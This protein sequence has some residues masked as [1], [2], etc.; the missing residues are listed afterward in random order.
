M[1]RTAASSS[2]AR[3]RVLE[4]ATR[5]F[6]AEGIHA[7]G[8]DRIIAEAGVAKAT[9]YSHFPAKS[10]LIRE[11]LSEQNDAQRAMVESMIS[12]CRAK[13]RSPRQT[14]FKIFDAVGD[15][16]CVPGYR[17][18]PFLN[19]AAE[20][21]DPAHPVRTV[22]ADYRRWFR[23]MLAELLTDAGHPDPDRTAGLLLLVRDGLTVGTELDDTKEICSLIRTFVGRV[24]GESAED[25]SAEA[26]RRTDGRAAAYLTGQLASEVGET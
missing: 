5:L 23:G 18:C 3:R 17:G 4:T 20:Y 15:I 19:A 10:D 24:L 1:A 9:F 2:P 25:S 26:P 7:V 21:P 6:Y 22:V 8:I 14:I 12:R 16:G 13:G 11:Y